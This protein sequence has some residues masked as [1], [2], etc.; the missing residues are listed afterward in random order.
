MSQVKSVRVETHPR[1]IRVG[2]VAVPRYEG[3]TGGFG[4]AAAEA[5]LA[6]SRLASKKFD[7]GGPPGGVQ[8]VVTVVDKTD[9]SVTLWRNFVGVRRWASRHGKAPL[10]RPSEYKIVELVCPHDIPGK[11]SGKYVYASTARAGMLHGRMCVSRQGAYGS[12]HGCGTSDESSIP[13]YSGYRVIRKRDFV[14]RLS[15][16]EKGCHSC[17]QQLKGPGA[18]L[19]LCL[20]TP[21]LRK[22]CGPKKR[23]DTIAQVRR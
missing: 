1:R 8:G 7:C 2:T 15:H 16:L 11:V 23:T 3:R 18:Q 21:A 9:R 14:G 12:E 5:R 10:K 17:A 19:L 13:Q 6:C 20:A 4:A 22:K